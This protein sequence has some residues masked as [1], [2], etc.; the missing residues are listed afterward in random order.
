MEGRITAARIDASVRRILEAKGR[1]GLATGT[2]VDLARLRAVVGLPHRLAHVHAHGRIDFVDDSIAT[3]PEAA[4]C[5]L[6]AIHGPL[7]VILGGSDKGAD[8]ASLA[9]A[10]AI[11]GAIPVLIGAT[12]P[13]LAAAMAVHGVSWRSATDL[14]TAIHEACAHL[15]DGG[16]VL[17]SPACASFDMFQ[18]FE[19]RGHKFAAAARAAR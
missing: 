7:A 19:D 12:A 3:T 13:R 18:G 17:L 9:K 5:A 11:R 1:L 15:P 2:Q 14:K 4:M 6:A 8:F 16:T 10:V